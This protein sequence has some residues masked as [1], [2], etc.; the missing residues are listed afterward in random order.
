MASLA[1]TVACPKVISPET[2]GK[3]LSCSRL[4][5]LVSTVKRYS[6]WE[7]S[8]H[9]RQSSQTWTEASEGVGNQ[10]GSALFKGGSC[11]FTP[12]NY[13]HGGMWE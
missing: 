7:M 11:Y 8:L 2:S 5:W 1:S 6:Q 4:Q 3:Q 9:S 12:A 13:H 10:R